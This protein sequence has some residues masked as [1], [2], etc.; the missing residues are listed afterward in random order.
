MKVEDYNNAIMYLESFILQRVVNLNYKVIK[1][2]KFDKFT[3]FKQTYEE[4][5]YFEIP[6]EGNDF[7]IFTS[8]EM[9]V[10]SRVWHDDVHI[11]LNKGFT[12]ENETNVAEEQCREVKEY[13]KDKLDYHI[14]SAMQRI[15]MAEVVSQL[16][17]YERFGR[18]IP[19]QRSFVQNE[20]FNK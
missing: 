8:P 18:Y 6:M 1:G 4:K 12:L 19:H 14:L 11:K 5:G 15:I 16:N 3:L 13:F 9:N 7:T 17:Y 10:K 2:K 20:L